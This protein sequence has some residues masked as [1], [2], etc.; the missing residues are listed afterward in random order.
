MDKNKLKRKLKLLREKKIRDARKSFWEFCKVKA[1]DFYKE[2]REYLKLLC[3][4][5][6]DLYYG[7]LKRGDG[8]RYRRLA[9]SVPP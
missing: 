5:L 3:N 9:L 2:D 6:E 7:R 8:F 1:P 4:T